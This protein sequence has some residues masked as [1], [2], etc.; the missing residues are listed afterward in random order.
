VRETAREHDVER[1]IRFGHKVVGAEWSSAQARWTVRAEH[2]DTG[3]TVTLTCGFFY[4]CSGYYHYDEGYTPEFEGIERFQGQVVHPQH[5]PDE[6]DYT[7]KRVVVVGSGATAVTLVPA[8]AETAAHVTMIQRSPSYIVAL[9]GEDPIANFLRRVLPAKAAYFLIRWKNV[10]FMSSTYALSKRRPELVKRVLRRALANRLPAGYDIDTHFTPKYDPWDQRMCLVPDG[11][12]FEAI[13]EGS[14]SVVTGHID[15][16]TE[17][18][19]RMESGE[20]LEADIV[21]TA[22]GL[23]ML[24]LAGLPLTVDGEAVDITERFAYKALMLD[25]VPNMAFSVGYTNASWTLKADLT[26]E[27]VCRLLNHM[28]A[29]SYDRV[30]PH[31]TDP[32]VQPEPFLDLASGYVLRALK[33]LPKQGSKPP[34]RLRQNYAYDIVTRRH[35]PLED[36][37]MEFARV[38]DTGAAHERTQPQPAAA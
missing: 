14:A 36:G 15:T 5:W 20:E 37:A 9:P 26:S 4:L 21:I 33:D 8:M 11:D 18:G 23:R 27:Y 1:H 7:G 10:A 30:M 24:G 29:H 12:L 6:L 17:S 25:R 2:A 34:W 28:D 16:F 32:T 22:T 35:R 31:N 38:A 19:V 3:E 13:G